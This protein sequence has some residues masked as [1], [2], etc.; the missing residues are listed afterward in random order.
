MFVLLSAVYHSNLRPIASGDFL[1]ASMIPFSI[2]LDG[3]IALDRFG[4]Y[5]NERV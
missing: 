3:S 4:P 5:V 2:L 1:P